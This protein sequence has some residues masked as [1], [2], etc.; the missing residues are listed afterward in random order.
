MQKSEWQTT[1]GRDCA[2]VERGR[3]VGNTGISPEEAA[4]E[5][6][7]EREVVREEK[8]RRARERVRLL[9]KRDAKGWPGR[10]QGSRQG[11]GSHDQAGC[12]GVKGENAKRRR[13][14]R[15]IPKRRRKRLHFVF[16]TSPHRFRFSKMAARS[17]VHDVGNWSP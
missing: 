6:E 11:V 17:R 2:T 9:A 12:C 8:D 13:G 4:E 1:R 7:K 5:E 14:P 15:S 3:T 16:R 10:T